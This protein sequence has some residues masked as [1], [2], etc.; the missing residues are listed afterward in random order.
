MT[1]PAVCHGRR[2]SRGTRVPVGV[3]LD[4]LADGC[5]SRR[6]WRSIRLLTSQVCG[7]LRL[8]GFGWLGSGWFGPMPIHWDLP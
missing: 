2:T 6:S 4:C 1:D 3:V 8:T 5:L 7:R